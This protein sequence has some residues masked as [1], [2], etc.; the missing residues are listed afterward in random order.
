MSKSET[1][2]ANIEKR[3]RRIT[4][5]FHSRFTYKPRPRLHTHEC[6]I[7]QLAEE[8]CLSMARIEDNI[9]IKVK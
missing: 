3:N 5:A 8:F 2:Q 9:R 7:S 1:R 6:V 4:E